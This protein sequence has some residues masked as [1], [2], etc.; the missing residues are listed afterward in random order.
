MCKE[1]HK[2][3][4]VTASDGFSLLCHVSKYLQNQERKVRAGGNKLQ[5]Q[6]ILNHKRVSGF[7]KNWKYRFV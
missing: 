2:L 5:K 6:V 3:K 1:I 4:N 7:K